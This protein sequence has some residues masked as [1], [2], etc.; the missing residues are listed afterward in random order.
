MRLFK[1]GVVSWRLIF[2]LAFAACI[3]ACAEQKAGIYEP[4]VLRIG[5]LPNENEAV[6][7]KQFSPLGN[8]LAAQL[9]RP[10]ELVVPG[11]Y[12]DFVDRFAR[13]DFDLG[14]FGGVTF[15][16]AQQRSDAKPLVMRDIDA[17]LSTYFLVRGDSAIREWDQMA[18]KSFSFG[19][20]LST[21]GH[22]MPRF[23]LR[24]RGI[25][26][27]SF[28]SDVRF[29]GAHDKTATWVTEGVVDIGAAN[30]HIVD[31]MLKDGRL[32]SAQVNILWETPPYAGYVWAVNADIDRSF[33]EDL[34]NSFLALSPVNP[35]HKI[36]LDALNAGG[37]LPASPEDFT[38]LPDIARSLGLLDS[39][40]S[41]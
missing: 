2:A 7:I 9:G 25:D 31:E 27:E 35:E 13:G 39:E 3:T 32:D 11:D 15:L 1:L 30:S 40:G 18:G 22:L 19:S 37:F 20:S 6:L 4:T 38:S 29:S 33:Q 24:E 12:A 5:V 41:Q 10:Y 8:Y 28:F 26:P 16:Q 17:R 21:S 36:I 23:F 14:Y 34:R